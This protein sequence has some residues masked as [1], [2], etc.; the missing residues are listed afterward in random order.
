MGTVSISGV[1]IEIYGTA[2]EASAYHAASASG[3][4]WATLSPLVR[5]QALVSATRILERQVWAGSPTQTVSKVQPQPASTQPLQWPRS[6]LLDRN[7]N[8]L[9]SAT[10]PQDVIDAAYEIALESA[11]STSTVNV[12]TA[13]AKY[14]VTRDRKKVGD[15]EVE[16]EREYFGTASRN[17]GRFSLNIMELIGLWL[18]GSER[19]ALGTLSGGACSQFISTDRP[20]GYDGTG[21]N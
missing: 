20:W 16:E 8:A 1:T 15:L 11:S 21:I 12:S 13:D 19:P 18:S 4:A 2:A 5:N 10:I 6:G 3:A 9:D 17:Q 7:G 14:R